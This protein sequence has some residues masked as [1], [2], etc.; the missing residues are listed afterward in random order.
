MIRKNEVFDM[1]VKQKEQK[2]I[3]FYKGDN[4]G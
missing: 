1:I 2:K 4:D 3:Y